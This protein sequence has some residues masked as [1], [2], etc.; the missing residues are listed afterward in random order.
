MLSHI[1][2][3]VVIW[4]VLFH[5]LQ[6]KEIKELTHFAQTVSWSTMNTSIIQLALKVIGCKTSNSAIRQSEIPPRT[7][8]WIKLIEERKIDQGKETAL[9][10]S[11]SYLAQRKRNFA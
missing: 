10:K 2:N 4:A 11:V 5:C 3:P 1:I 8:R 9:K 7:C 6:N